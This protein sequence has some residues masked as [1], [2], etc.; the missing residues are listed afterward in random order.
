MAIIAGDQIT[1]VDITDAYSV[2]LSTESIT[3]TGTTADGTNLGSQ[4]STQ[5][6]LSA[7]CGTSTI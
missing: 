1:I 7:L 2:F 3:F 4:Q 5:V 6:R